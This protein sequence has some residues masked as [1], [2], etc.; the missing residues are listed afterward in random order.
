MPRIFLYPLQEY[1]LSSTFAQ[2]DLHPTLIDTVAKIGYAHPTPIQSALI[3]VMLSGQDVIGQAQTGTGKTAAFTLPALSNLAV[4]E[5]TVQA[6]VLV[7][8]R[9]LATQV[10]TAVFNYGRDLGVQV[11][12]IFG[13]QSYSRQIKRLRK[14]VDVVVA[15]P[16]RLLDLLNQG[17]L[18]LSDVRTVVLDEADEMLSMG[19]SED[20][21]AILDRT[22]SD[23]QTVCMSAT[24]PHGIRK[25]ASQYMRNPQSCEV[26]TGAR[27]ADA[28]EQRVYTVKGRDKTAALARLLEAEPVDSALVFARTRAGTVTLA[29]A[30]SARGYAA[31][32]INGEMTQ[33]ARDAVLSKFRNGHL[34][35][36][37]GTDVAARGLD[38]DHV[39]HVFNYDL[40]HDPEVYVHRVG[41]TGRAGKSGVAITLATP[42]QRREISRI[43]SY[44]KQKMTNAGLPSVADVEALREARF[45]ADLTEQLDG[46]A[47]DRERKLV[48]DLVAAGRDPMDVAAAALA[49]V[50]AAEHNP[51]LEH[52]GEV[53]VQSDG[54]HR[55]PSHGKRPGK[56]DRRDRAPRGHDSNSYDS[57][58]HEDGMVR[59]SID[60]G[61][62]RNVRPGQVVSAL[63]RTADIPGKAIGRISVEQ[64]KTLV[65]VPQEFVSQ[66]LAQTGAYRFGKHLVSVELA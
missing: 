61:L 13:G 23:R 28:I 52:V 51:T 40:P 30:L 65:D 32:A 27:T 64:K 38:I 46:A 66:V 60:A 20:L 6:L 26:G 17:A 58:S 10:A 29:N 2:F 50:R 48:T 3:P 55:A 35:I 54:G 43:E 9:E 41:R 45:V 39:S 42:A 25:L 7:P 21:A 37:V 11:L 16:G 34:A 5:G 22:P 59:L 62:S 19:F 15:T 4:G 44:T 56:H 31:E 57:N 8:T 63:A 33:P 49:L 18:D 12:P 53:D 14:G 24:I 36:L 47:T 1:T